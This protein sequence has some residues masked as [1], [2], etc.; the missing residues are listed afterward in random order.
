MGYFP[1]ASA[2]DDWAKDNCDQCEN[3]Y[4]IEPGEAGYDVERNCPIE[5]AHLI[6]NYDERN[7]DASIL[8]HLIPRTKDGLGNE[9]CKMFRSRYMHEEDDHPD[10]CRECFAELY[11][12]GEIDWMEKQILNVQKMIRKQEGKE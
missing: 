5:L 2:W 10:L 11:D 3:C 6:F 4:T 8:D 12:Q 9:Q 1:N 7:N